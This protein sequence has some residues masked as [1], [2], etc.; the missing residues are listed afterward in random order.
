MLF[1]LMRFTVAYRGEYLMKF[2]YIFT[3]IRIKIAPILMLYMYVGTIG[4]V[5]CCLSIYL[6]FSL[7]FSVYGWFGCA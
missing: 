3:L 4:A 6:L 1:S 5:E 7:R 2:E